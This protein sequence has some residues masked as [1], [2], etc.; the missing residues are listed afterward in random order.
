LKQ[1]LLATCLACLC[2]PHAVAQNLDTKLPS[3]FGNDANAAPFDVRQSDLKMFAHAFVEG[4]LTYRNVQ[5]S[6]EIKVHQY[7]SENPRMTKEEREKYQK[8]LTDSEALKNDLDERFKTAL[9]KTIARNDTGMKKEAITTSYSEGFQAGEEYARKVLSTEDQIVTMDAAA[10]AARDTAQMRRG[11]LIRTYERAEKL[12]LTAED[13]TRVTEGEAI[14][15]T[16]KAP[17]TA[18]KKKR[19]GY[20]CTPD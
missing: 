14:V 8:D 10:D 12:G 13:A 9:I 7:A 20:I 15:T 18:P 5:T 3:L 16:I 6:L 11:L 2:A 19:H 1:I 4:Y 17:T